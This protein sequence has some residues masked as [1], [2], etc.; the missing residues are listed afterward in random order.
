VVG[1]AVLAGALHAGWTAAAAQTPGQSLFE[2]SCSACHTIGGGRLVGPD[3]LGVG[4]RRSEAWLIA[5]IQHSQQLVAAGDSTAVALFNEYEAMPMPDQPL[6]ADDI[7]QVLG[8]IR[9]AAPS[10]AAP[11]PAVAEASEEQILLGGK[12][13]QGTARLANGGAPC[14]SCHDVTGGAMTGGGGLARELTTAFSR[15]GAPG[16]QAVIAKPPFPVMQRAYRD[17]PLTDAETAALVGFLR[18]VAEQPAAAPARGFDLRLFV[19]GLGGSVVLLV[20]YALLWRRR[21]KGSVNQR[22]FDRQIRTT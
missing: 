6:S 20:L 12:L 18:R 19:M 5:F 21:L 3:L 17:H 4:E 7:R 10:A 11:G 14:T 16:L 9:G 13:F 2:A 1:V 22:I 8:Y 15:L